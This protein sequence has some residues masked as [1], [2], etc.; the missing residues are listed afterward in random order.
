MPVISVVVATYNRR[1][2]LERALASVAQQTERDWECLVCDDG[3]SDDTV[4]YVSALA[5]RDP[6]FRLVPGPRHGRPSG[7]R[8][9]GIREARGEWIALLD[10]DDLWHPAKLECQLRAALAQ[11]CDAVSTRFEFFRDANGPPAFV[12]VHGLPERAEP[13]AL[14]HVL[15]LRQPYPCTPSNMI[16]RAALLSAGAF[17]EGAEYRAVEDY[18]LWCRLVAR[19]GFVFLMLDGDALTLARDEGDDSISNWTLP[20]KPDAIRQR[21][22]SLEILTRT[23]AANISLL[24]GSDRAAVIDAAVSGADDCAARSYQVGWR[25]VSVRAYAIA[26]TLSLLSRDVPGALRRLS[27]A[28]RFGL[29]GAVR[30]RAEMPAT[31]GPL[32][33]ASMRNTMTLLRQ[34]LFPARPITS[35]TS[36]SS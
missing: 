27:R 33:R 8:N 10:D 7:P 24:R 9:R 35:S 13:L 17:D 28:I 12:E 29:F 21:W 23:T 15:L 22:A 30:A 6:R 34:C 36:L 26:C 16:R 20:L 2:L 4:A 31:V 3:S 25:S 32:A 19:P 18:D 11:P 5:E 14:T 1:P